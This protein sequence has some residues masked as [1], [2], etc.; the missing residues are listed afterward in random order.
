[1]S[2][3]HKILVIDDEK[4]VCR[5]LQKV[6]EQEG[7]Y[8]ESAS[9]AEEGIRLIKEKQFQMALIDLVLPG[10]DGLEACKRIKA[11]FP[12]VKVV[13]MSGYIPKLQETKDVFESFGGCKTIIEKPFGGDEIVSLAK[14][15]FERRQGCR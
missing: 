15:F 11:E 12:M 1:M 10:I 2:L 5:A 7:Y 4:I 14:D 6:L 3:G 8:V 13:L 9:T